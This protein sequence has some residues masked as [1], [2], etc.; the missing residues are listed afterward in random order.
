MAISDVL[1]HAVKEVDSYLE[2]PSIYD[3]P[4]LRER[5]GSV[6]DSMDALRRELDRVPEESLL[7]PLPKVEPPPR[8]LP[9]II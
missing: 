9:N 2:P 8:Q 6:R 3:E 1:F 7:E 4:K 5:I